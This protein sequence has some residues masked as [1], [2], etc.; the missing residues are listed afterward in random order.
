MI[1]I[2]N[3][4]REKVDKAARSVAGRS[5]NVEWEDLSQ[6]MW[7]WMLENPNQYDKYCNMEDPYRNLIKIAKQELY[8]QNS[9][10][11]H[12][13]GDYTYTNAEV[14]GLLSEYLIDVTLE[15]IAEHVDLVEGMLMVRTDAPAYFNAIVGRYVKGEEVASNLL[16]KA[17]DKLVNCMNQVNKSARY[18][19]EGPGARRAMSNSAVQAKSW[20]QME[21][22]SNRGTNWS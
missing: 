13:T 4:F 5:N 8:K 2:S 22:N 20:N 10:Y 17:V 14:R 21:Q 1:E 15:S 19:Y 12:F 16:S 7:V 6:D 3:D 9:A 11:E 18:S